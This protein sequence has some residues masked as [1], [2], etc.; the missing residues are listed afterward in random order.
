MYDARDKESVEFFAATGRY[1]AWLQSC[2]SM[3]YQASKRRKIPFCQFVPKQAPKSADGVGLCDSA[4]E[5]D[6]I[7]RF[8]AFQE[9]AKASQSMLYHRENYPVRIENIE[10]GP[11]SNHDLVTCGF[12]YTAQ[13]CSLRGRKVCVRGVHDFLYDQNVQSEYRNYTYD[14]REALAE[15]R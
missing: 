13:N 3:G 8:I 5:R 12:R 6:E 9:N 15:P 14:R 1:G 2:D 11:Y 4:V 10:D 7:I